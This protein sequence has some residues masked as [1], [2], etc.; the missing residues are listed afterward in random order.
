MPIAYTVVAS[1]SNGLV[2]I[3]SYWTSV[4]HESLLNRCRSRILV[5]VTR[6]TYLL[7]S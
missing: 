2:G 6:V 5:S 4:I 7:M 3:V 1:I